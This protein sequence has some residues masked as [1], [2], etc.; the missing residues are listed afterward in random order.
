MASGID[1]KKAVISAIIF[2][3]VYGATD[4]FHQSFTQGR[5][6]RLRDVGFDALGSVIITTGMHKF[7]GKNK[8]WQE[9]LL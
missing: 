9:K 3:I 8:K 6:S 7:L 2:T 5:E 1:K 4:E